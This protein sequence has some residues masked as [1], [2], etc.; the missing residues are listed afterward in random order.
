MDQKQ[1]I[2]LQYLLLGLI[3]VILNLKL[4][5]FG[6]LFARIEVAGYLNQNMPITLLDKIG[7]F[8]LDIFA[9]PLALFRNMFVHYLLILTII[10]STI[11][12][13]CIIDRFRTLERILLFTGA[14]E[15]W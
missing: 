14:I 4:M 12:L 9:W 6:S 2:R 7:Y 5:N 15:K 13:V 1:E 3:F 8:I 11:L 10:F